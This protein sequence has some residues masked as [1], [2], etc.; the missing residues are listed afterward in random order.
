M[1]ST[2]E[3]LGAQHLDA[4]RTFLTR[5]VKQHLYLL[6]LLEDFGLESSDA[7]A[8]HAFYGRLDGEALTAVLFV[9]GNGGLV[10][11]SQGDPA[12][13]NEVTAPL[14][15]KVQLKACIG[16]RA[17]VDAVVRALGQ[18]ARPRVSVAQ[19][20]FTVSADDM[21]PFT[22]PLLRLAREADVPRL[23]ALSA[24]DLEERMGHKPLELDATALTQRVRRRVRDARSYIYEEDGDIAFKID[25]GSRSQWGAE[26]EGL[27]T[28]RHHRRKGHALLNLGQISRHLLSSLPRLSL[29][30]NEAD[31]VT[32]KI[33]RRVG[34]VAGAS[35]RLVLLDAPS[36]R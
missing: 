2:I 13:F 31:E 26:L 33:A 6:G 34:Y 17:P 20:L 36:V 21:G 10:V 1:P 24:E 18:G 11:P 7:R 19:R 28:H 14:V 15:G 35:Q 8:P 32:A 4:L 12:H 9:G 29:R 23:V 5:D 22:N 30:V 25:I 3:R 27:H 16:D